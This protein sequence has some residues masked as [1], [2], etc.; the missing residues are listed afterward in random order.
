MMQLIYW[1]PSRR[2]YLVL[3]SAMIMLTSCAKKMAFQTSTVVPTAEGRVKIK[4][5]NNGNYSININIT[6][7][8]PPDRLTP[9]K[10]AYIA[11]LVTDTESARNLGQLKSSKGF[12]NG[13]YSASL[14]AVSAI[15][16]ISIFITAEDSPT[17]AYPG[18]PVVLTAQ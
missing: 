13:K 6:H 10:K 12:L 3:L 5:D 11:W 8:A 9:P 4:K 7:L 17:P 14:D 16:P 2:M 1:L 18:T 15:K